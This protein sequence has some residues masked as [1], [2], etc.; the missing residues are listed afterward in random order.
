MGELILHIGAP[1]TGTTALQGFLFRNRARL[2][3]Y[4]VHYPAFTDQPG[5]RTKRNGIFLQRYCLNKASSL[6]SRSV[7]DKG[8]NLERLSQSL[9][10]H[11]RTLI[12][13]EEFFVPQL[14]ILKRGQRFGR[15]W[16]TVGEVVRAAGA[17]GVTV[18]VYLRRQDEW[19]ASLWRQSVKVGQTGK[20]LGDYCSHALVRHAMDYRSLFESIEVG[21]GG[22]QIVVR[23]YNRA[24]FE[25]GDIFHDFC[26]AVGIPWDDGYDLPNKDRNP[27]LTFDVAE[28]LRPFAG[29]AAPRSALRQE[30]VIP[31]AQRL[32]RQN[33]DPPGTNPFDEEMARLL[34]EPFLAGNEAVATRYLDGGPLLS[35]EYGGRPVWEP[36]GGRIATCR[37]TFREVISEYRRA[38]PPTERL[39]GLA[40]GISEGAKRPV[41]AM[42]EKL[43]QRRTV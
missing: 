9:S 40:Y 13:N 10:G 27:S 24:S 1:K 30:V 32:S 11:E 20:A 39:R 26:A 34:V 7:S 43:V 18:V 15:Y 22:A 37:T 41:R 4:G 35:D 16:E 36:D 23:R 17:R 12:T 25:G 29:V 42:I 21:L 38:Q 3:G 6:V 28:A 2:A 8:E 14:R 19:A 5:L 31:L 33:P